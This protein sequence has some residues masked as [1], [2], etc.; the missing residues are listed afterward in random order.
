MTKE[1]VIVIADTHINST[2]GLCPPGV[3]LDDG[4]QYM[5]SATQKWLWDT[6]LQ[7]LDDLDRITKGYRKTFVLNGDIGELDDKNRSW[8]TI[9]RSPSKVLDLCREVFVPAIGK[10][11]LF[12][13]R[14]TEAHTGKSA[15]IE[16][17]L[18]ADLGAIPD[19]ERNTFSW[20]HLRA[21]FGGVK[22]DVSHHGSMGSLPWTYANAS[23]RLV[24]ETMM[25]YMKWGEDYPDIVVRSHMHRFVDSGRTFDSRAVFTPCWQFKTSYLFRLGKAN[26]Y[27]HIGSLVF[28][29][30]DGNYHLED[31]RYKPKRKAPWVNKNQKAK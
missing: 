31:L 6:W 7:F 8:Q 23:N 13:V 10:D 5:R 25:Q 22:F 12:V 18:A 9:V 3:T 4:G 16:E 1:A 19:N 14:G 27:P 21:L 28:L 11:D 15:W 26:A 17:E 24:V 20:W 30:E 29:C 2:L